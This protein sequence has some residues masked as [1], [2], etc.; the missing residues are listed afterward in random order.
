MDSV[1]NRLR[2][3]RNPA[4]AKDIVVTRALGLILF[5]CLA[6]IPAWTGAWAKTVTAKSPDK[7]ITLTVSDRDGFLTYT[8]R[9]D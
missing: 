8:V 2:L 4:R 1:I 3:V 5:C 7:T 6:L 9:F